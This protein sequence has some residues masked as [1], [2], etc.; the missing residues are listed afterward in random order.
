MYKKYSYPAYYYKPSNK[1]SSRDTI[2]LTTKKGL[3][4][5]VNRKGR[6]GQVGSS[7]KLFV[8]GQL[9]KIAVCSNSCSEPAW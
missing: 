1:Y 6:S 8:T 2:H 5:L 3:W 9:R 7:K 4:R